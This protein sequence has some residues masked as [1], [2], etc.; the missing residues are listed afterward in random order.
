MEKGTITDVPISTLDALRRRGL[1]ESGWG[2]YVTRAN[3][4]PALTDVKLT[5]KGCWYAT[6]LRYPGADIDTT[7]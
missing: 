3:A 6:R 5:P 4:F 7:R 1:I 2:G